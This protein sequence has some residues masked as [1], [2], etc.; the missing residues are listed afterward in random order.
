ME[1]PTVLVSCS[2]LG[3]Y[4][5]G[6]LGTFGSWFWAGLG[7][8]FGVVLCDGASMRREMWTAL[9]KRQRLRL[10]M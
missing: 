9:L 10:L 2:G 1:D 5:F 8:D 7:W 3:P 4:R 6:V